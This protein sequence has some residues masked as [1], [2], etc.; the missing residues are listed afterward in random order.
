MKN[1]KYK[2]QNEKYRMQNANWGKILLL[3]N[4]VFSVQY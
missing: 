1:T 4:F 3:I 2:I